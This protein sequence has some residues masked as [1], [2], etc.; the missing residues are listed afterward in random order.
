MEWHKIKEFPPR[1]YEKIL[2]SDGNVIFVGYL[3]FYK[4]S[5]GTENI[6]CWSSN[7][8]EYVKGHASFVAEIIPLYWMPLPKQP[9]LN[10]REDDLMYLYCGI[11]K[12]YFHIFLDKDHIDRC[13]A[14]IVDKYL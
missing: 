5:D 6:I 10:K 13:R 1:N 4:D 14:R 9:E 11:C 12:E 8:N 7:P 2:I 3:H